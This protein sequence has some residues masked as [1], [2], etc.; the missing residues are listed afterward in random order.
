MTDEKIRTILVDDEERALDVLSNLLGSFCPQVELLA[1]YS[2][3]E[4]AVEGIRSLRPG[5]VFLDIEMPNYAGYEIVRFFDKIDFEIIFVTAYDSYA[6]KAFEVAAVDYLLKPVDIGRLKAAVVKSAS[7][8][9]NQELVNKYEVLI[10]SLE[11]NKVKN[12][13]VAEKG[14]QHVLAVDQIIA[15]EARESYSCIHTNHKKYLA[16]KNLKHF[17]NLFRDNR[18]FFRTHKSWIINMSLV[19]KYARSSGEIHLPGDIIARLSKY[20]K[21]EFEKTLQSG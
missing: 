10:E 12:I 20:R 11:S 4:A 6:V 1:K 18:N 5:L 19:H 13:V 2:N 14:S 8:I 15:V 3:V 9:R 16:S 7:R 21:E 17:E